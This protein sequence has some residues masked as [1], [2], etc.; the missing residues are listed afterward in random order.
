M[1]TSAVFIDDVLSGGVPPMEEADRRAM[2]GAW[3][4]KFRLFRGNYRA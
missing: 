4:P 2:P 1:S 3:E